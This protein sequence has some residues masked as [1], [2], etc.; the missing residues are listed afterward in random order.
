MAMFHGELYKKTLPRS[1]VPAYFHVPYIEAGYR[2]IHQPWT[3][4][5]YSIF[6]NNMETLNVWTHVVGTLLMTS[7]LYQISVNFDLGDPYMWPLL[8]AILSFTVMFVTSSTAHMFSHKSME[9]NCCMFMADFAC[10]GLY[11]YGTILT[12][13]YYS[14]DQCFLESVLLRNV[15]YFGSVLA[16]LST[17]FGSMSKAIVH[18]LHSKRRTALIVSGLGAIY[19]LSN[20]PILHRIWNSEWTDGIAHH[21]KQM[22]SMIGVCFFYST[23]LPERLSPGTFD[24]IGNSHQ[25]FHILFVLCTQNHL[26][27]VVWDIN[28]RQTFVVRRPPPSLWNIFGIIALICLADILTMKYFYSRFKKRCLKK[29]T[30]SNELKAKTNG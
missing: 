20:I 26:D 16:I 7:R 23:K 6:Y 18:D 15:F 14:L 3:F 4:Y 24:F 22:A 12:H 25:I 30:N 28:F 5:I 13:Y 11:G 2:Y 17:A 21:L 29:D 1:R 9:V 19:L 10:I 8:A 27:G